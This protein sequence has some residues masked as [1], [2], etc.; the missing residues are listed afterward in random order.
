M[1]TFKITGPDGKSYRVSGENAEG[2]FQALQQHL[3]GGGTP[4]PESQQSIDARSELSSLTQ[5]AANQGDG[6]GRNVDSFMRGAADVM[7]LGMADEMA[8][9]GGALTGIGGEFGDYSRNLRR[10]RIKQDQR[11]QQDKVASLAG[12]ITGGVTGGLG[13]ARNGLSMSANAINRGS[14]LGR[15]AAA[16]AGEGAILGGAHGAGS[17][18]GV[19]GRLKGAG[20]GGATG[21]VLGGAAPLAVAG[22]SQVGGMAAAPVA[23]RLF[24][25]RYAERA[26][27]EGVR[28]S[29]MTVDDIAQALTRSQADDQGMFTVADAMG[30]SGQRM[31]STVARTPHNERQAVIEELQARQ[32]GQGDRLS[33]FLSEGFGAPDTAAQ[34]AASLTARRSADATTNY[35]AARDGAGAVNLNNAIGEIDQLLGRDPIL[36][37]TAL[38]AGPL[39]PRLMALRDQLQ[40]DGEQL[41]DFDR[42]LNI[43][44]D[45]FQQMQRN[46]QVANDMRGVYGALDEALENA[47][48]GYRAA[49]DTFRQQSRAID[50]VDTG[51]NAASG[52]MRSGDTVPQFNAMAPD[53]QS[54]FR[55]GYA[56]PLISRV[57]SA[58]MS[59]TTNKA[60]GL[61]TPKTGEEFPAFALPERADQLGNR[62]AREQRMFDTANAALGGSKTADNL[63]DAAEMSKFD[64]GVMSKL[65][66]G[67]LVGA[68]MDGGRRLMG[69]AQG[70]PPRVVEQVARVLMETNPEAARQ[71]LQGGIGRLSRSDQVRA[72]IIASMVSSGAAGTGRLG[73]P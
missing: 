69:E 13:L 18:E 50:A 34:R 46:P 53:E 73:A 24:P 20:I 16:S 2:A 32:A 35:G 10:E 21:L 40:R 51:R 3:G 1:P 12:R 68:I 42:V 49:N 58:S 14:S 67:D 72:R 27:G 22:V 6:F 26:I 52:R 36:G 60:R 31:L 61:I 19:E 30:N 29:G 64:P 23:A 65:V 9:A 66:R 47:S 25:E 44:S 28:R 48:G 15:V 5:Q 45:L 8:A 33:N 55:A 56:D 54:A 59:P 41:I 11:D 7:S 63:A 17:G 38:S 57:E 37:D 71:L 62:I 39:G 43:K 70:M 4:Q